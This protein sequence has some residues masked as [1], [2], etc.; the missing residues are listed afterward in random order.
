MAGGSVVRARDGV[1]PTVKWPEATW[2]Q[3]AAQSYPQP[4]KP[5]KFVGVGSH[6][7]GQGNNHESYDI[8]PDHETVV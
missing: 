6:Y 4:V 3:P 5:F 2:E 7:T 1:E 8:G